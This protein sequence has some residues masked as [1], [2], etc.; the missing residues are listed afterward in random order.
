MKK[1]TENNTFNII[2]R[3]HNIT[4]ESLMFK[5]SDLTINITSERYG[6]YD[7]YIKKVIINEDLAFMV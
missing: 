2:D 4:N 7:F 1:Y 3:D 6:N 5:N